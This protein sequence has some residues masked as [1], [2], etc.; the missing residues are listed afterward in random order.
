MTNSADGWQRAAKS[1]AICCG[2]KRSPPPW[3]MRGGDGQRRR[4]SE[5]FQIGGATKASRLGKPTA[6]VAAW[7]DV[8]AA[9]RTRC[10]GEIRSI[11]AAAIPLP[12]EKPR[13][14]GCKAG[15]SDRNNSKAA[16]AS[17]SHCSQR[18]VPVLRPY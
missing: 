2:N 7:Q 12:M 6:H 5:V 1:N 11:I 3:M 18:T 9:Q 15:A 14:D 4:H 13:T 17:T 16:T 10:F 8:N